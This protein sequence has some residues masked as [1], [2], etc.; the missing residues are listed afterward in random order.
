MITEITTH[1]VAGAM[2][3]VRIFPTDDKVEEGKAHNSYMLR[4]GKPGHESQGEVRLKFQSGTLQ[5][6]IPNGITNEALLAVI[7]D[8][9]QAYQAGLL[10][11]HENSVAI[12]RL[13]DAL[14]VLK[15]RTEDRV[16]R[17]VE[18]TNKV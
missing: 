17:G 12:D 8:R 16:K 15:I 2:N 14:D 18:G 6:T 1:H 11:C 9:L 13:Q 10:K 3:T 5:D 4:I 7:I